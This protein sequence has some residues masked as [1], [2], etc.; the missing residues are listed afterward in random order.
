MNI[1]FTSTMQS[2]HISQR[3]TDFH[4]SCCLR[5]GGMSFLSGLSCNGF[6]P[7]S[8]ILLW[9]LTNVYLVDLQFESSFLKYRLIHWTVLVLM[10]GLCRMYHMCFFKCITLLQAKMELE[11]VLSYFSKQNTIA[12]LYM[13]ISLFWDFLQLV[14]AVLSDSLL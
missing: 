6:T 1:Q 5:Y 13:C 10:L 11:N 12:M 2:I 8:L 7:A 14:E 3:G 4:R 9:Q